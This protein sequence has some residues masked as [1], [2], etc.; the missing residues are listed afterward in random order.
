MNSSEKPVVFSLGDHVVY[1]LQGVG[2]INKIEEKTLRGNTCMYYEIF[3]EI[4][5]MTVMVPVE[6][7]RKSVV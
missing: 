3:L 6:R 2:L 5:D 4:S 7:D 1:P